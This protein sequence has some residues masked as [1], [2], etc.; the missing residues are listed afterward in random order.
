MRNLPTYM[1]CDAA[2]RMLKVSRSAFYRA[3]PA[4]GNA[5]RGI[6]DIAAVTDYLNKHAVNIAKPLR[7][8]LPLCDE[9]DVASLLLVNGRPATENQVRRFCRRK[10]FPIPHYAFSKSVVRFPKGAVEWWQDAK[11]RRLPVGSRKFFP[12]EV[13]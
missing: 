13:C 5:A 1:T 9:N 10:L 3:F 2:M 12:A 7:Y 4:A 11:T 8:P 6:I